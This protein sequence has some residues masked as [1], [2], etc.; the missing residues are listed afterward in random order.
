MWSSTE[1]A[2]LRAL[3]AE[4]LSASQIGAQLGRTRN[5]VL[6]QAHRLGLRIGNGTRGR[7]RTRPLLEPRIPF[8]DGRRRPLGVAHPIEQ[9]DMVTGCRWPLGEPGAADFRYCGASREW[10][11]AGLVSHRYCARHGRVA[12]VWCDGRSPLN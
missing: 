4:Q 6:G 8:A 3:Q 2:Q 12:F 9:L 1:V 7:R 11:E 10:P 5:A